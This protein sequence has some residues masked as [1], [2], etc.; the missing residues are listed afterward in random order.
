MFRIT[1]PT[2]WITFRL[3][4]DMSR[5][6][7][8]NHSAPRGGLILWGRNIPPPT[9]RDLKGIMFSLSTEETV[10]VCIPVG[11]LFYP[12]CFCSEDLN[13]LPEMFIVGSTVHGEVLSFFTPSDKW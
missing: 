1:H 8:R 11:K 13:T 6:N 12:F 10:F 2:G 7:G 3:M 9:N 4:L 5:R